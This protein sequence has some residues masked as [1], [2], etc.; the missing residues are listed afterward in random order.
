MGKAGQLL[1]YL[2]AGPYTVLGLLLGGIAVLFG[3]R[4]ER[5]RGVVEV[6]GGRIGGVLAKLPPVLGFAAMTLGHVILAVDRSSLA[7]LRL[8]EHVHVRQYE[9]WGPFFLPAYLLSSLLQLLRGRHPYRE[10]HFERQA[11]A[12]VAEHRRLVRDSIR[13]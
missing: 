4:M 3:A 6:S 13:G 9:R 10:N 12:V 7:Q 11:Y 8:H 5:H 2:W 1:R